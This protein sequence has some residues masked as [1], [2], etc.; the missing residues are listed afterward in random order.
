MTSSK[1]T[2][3]RNDVWLGVAMAAGFLFSGCA[4]NRARSTDAAEPPKDPV[5]E[6]RRSVNEQ[7]A[8]A[9]LAL[10]DNDYDRAIRAADK[11]RELLVDTNSVEQ[12]LDRPPQHEF[13]LDLAGAMD[14]AG[15]IP[16]NVHLRRGDYAG[17]LE[18]LPTYK[19]CSA[20]EQAYMD[21]SVARAAEAIDDPSFVEASAAYLSSDR[22]ASRPWLVRLD[23]VYLECRVQTL[24]GAAAK[25]REAIASFR[26]DVDQ[27]GLPDDA[28]R[29]LLER[30]RAREAECL[31][32]RT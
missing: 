12:V 21:R 20:T 8:L 6:L 24:A 26:A 30:S 10:N 25:G 22:A 15:V 4:S 3:R 27:S 13:W 2:G 11:I 1:V 17:A 29:N 14:R 28:K 5:V 16:I 18:R 7:L 23:A 32:D 19:E 31:A 9:D